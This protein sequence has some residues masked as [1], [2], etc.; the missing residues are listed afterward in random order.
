M[1][2]TDLYKIP[3]NRGLELFYLQDIVIIEN[4]NIEHDYH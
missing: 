3:L 2:N 4:Y 1:K